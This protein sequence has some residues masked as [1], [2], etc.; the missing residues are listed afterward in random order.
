MCDRQLDASVTVA[1]SANYTSVEVDT[2]KLL[3][4]SYHAS[5]HKD[6]TAGRLP[7]V[8]VIAPPTSGALMVRVAELTT[9]RV[10]GCPKMKMPA[11][12]IFYQSVSGYAGADHVK[13]EVTSENGD[14]V[15]YDVTITVKRAPAQSQQPSV[16]PGTRGLL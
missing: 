8:G 9:A 12:V 4:L 3:R 7:T 14:V 11:R 15:I 5:A 13:Y 10:S 6:C 16:E 2:N 1:Q